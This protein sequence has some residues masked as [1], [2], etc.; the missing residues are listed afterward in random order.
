MENQQK[1]SF[2]LRN[3]QRNLSIKS[4]KLSKK[5]YNF[6]SVRAVTMQKYRNWINNMKF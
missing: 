2:C 3:N 4:I 6:K 5:E 1:L